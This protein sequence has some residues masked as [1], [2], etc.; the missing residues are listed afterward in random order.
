MSS[1]A[2]KVVVCKVEMKEESIAAVIFQVIKDLSCT[3]TALGRE[4]VIPD[5]F[6]CHER[7]SSVA[8]LTTILSAL[9][10]FSIFWV[11]SREV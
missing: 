7:A 9:L 8:A 11:A 5:D 3:L 1:V 10:D 4:V 2:T 6:P